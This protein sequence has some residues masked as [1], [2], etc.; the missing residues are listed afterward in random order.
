LWGQ[1]ECLHRPVK[2]VVKKENGRKKKTKQ[3]FRNRQGGKVPIVKIRHTIKGPSRRLSA[4]FG[5]KQGSGGNQARKDAKGKK[6]SGG[7]KSTNL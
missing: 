5:E 7:N 4:S 1:G 3:G 6:T 2:P